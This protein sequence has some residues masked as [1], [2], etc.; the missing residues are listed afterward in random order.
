M[1]GYVVEL[2]SGMEFGEYVRQNIFKPLGMEHTSIEP[3]H[4]DN[5][6]VYSKHR[7]MKSYKNYIDN[8]IAMGNYRGYV[9]APT[10][11]AAE[12]HSA[13]LMT[14]A[15]AL[16]DKDARLFENPADPGGA[17]HRRRLLRRFRCPHMGAR[18]CGAGNRCSHLRSQRRYD[19]LSDEYDV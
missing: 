14:Y 13:D 4:S 10:R 9:S 5:Q 7:E 3:N 1:A 15:Q 16:V 2:L 11:G 18:L 6:Y 19:V 17:F 8:R 12:V